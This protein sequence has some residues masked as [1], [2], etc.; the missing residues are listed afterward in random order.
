MMRR[1]TNQKKERDDSFDVREFE[2]TAM[3]SSLV[4]K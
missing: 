1:K 3:N 4:F 2:R